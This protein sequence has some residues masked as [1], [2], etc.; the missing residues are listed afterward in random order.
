LEAEVRA[1]ASQLGF[2]GTGGG[3]GFDA[4]DFEPSKARQKLGH[5]SSDGDDDAP[6]NNKRKREFNPTEEGARENGT[7][8]QKKAKD[9]KVV[10]CRTR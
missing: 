3:G 2:A 9:A 8:P 5:A 4:S 1:F 6:I 7:A 10:L